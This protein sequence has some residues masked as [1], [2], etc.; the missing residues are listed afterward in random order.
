MIM[1][2][3]VIQ[4][5]EI[6]AVSVLSLTGYV[7]A[8]TVESLDRE[9]TELRNRNCSKFVI[10]C[11][12]VT[13]SSSHGIATLVKHTLELRDSDGDIRYTGISSDMSLTIKILNLQQYFNDYDSLSAATASY[14]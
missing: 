8:D 2:R 14:N 12:G 4:E 10:D 3:L 9:L 11:S 5:K 13:Y 7:D 6:A 1:S